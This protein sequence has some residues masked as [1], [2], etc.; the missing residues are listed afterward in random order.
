MVCDDLI[1][2]FES[3]DLGKIVIRVPAGPRGKPI[4]RVHID[5]LFKQ[6]ISLY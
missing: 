5:E 3:V 2:G 1:S 6:H 4:G